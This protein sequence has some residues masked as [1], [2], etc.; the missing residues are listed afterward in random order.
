MVVLMEGEHEPG[1]LWQRGVVSWNGGG[2][3]GRSVSGDDGSVDCSGRSGDGGGYGVV[4]MVW[5]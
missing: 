4:V 3:G 5:W 1:K 2:G